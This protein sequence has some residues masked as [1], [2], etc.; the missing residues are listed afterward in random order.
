MTDPKYDAPLAKN[1]E[2]ANKLAGNVESLHD[3]WQDEKEY[4]DWAEYEAHAKK[5][6]EAQDAKFVHLKKKPF[7][8]RF[9]KGGVFIDIECNVRELKV[10]QINK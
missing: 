4:E 1:A 6:V 3:R 10:T 9:E 8:L 7:V 2:I 5:L